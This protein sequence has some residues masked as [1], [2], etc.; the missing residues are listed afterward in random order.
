M[1]QIRGIS[2]SFGRTVALRD[3]SLE[4]AAGSSMALLGPNGAGKTT[5]AKIVLGLVM[6]DSGSA[7][8][9]SVPV[10]APSSRRGVRYLPENVVFHAWARPMQLFGQLERIR[11]S[12]TPL[13][14][15]E[16]ASQ[17]ACDHLL[18]RPMGKMSRGQR[19]RIAL[20][21]CTCGSP[22]ILILDEP[23]S[24]LDPEG[25]V[26][27]RKL[28]RSLSAQGAT[29]LLNSHLLGEVESVCRRAAFIREGSLV[30]EGDLEELSRT[31]GEVEVWSDTP[32]E[33]AD[34]LR[35]LGLEAQ[36]G[37]DSGTVLVRLG[38]HAEEVRDVA[39]AVLE[40]GI[41]FSGMRRRRESLED[42]FLRM[43]KGD[44]PVS[45]HA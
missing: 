28:I 38:P 39:A 7:S 16:R 42:I 33:M 31:R 9:G 2:K 26:H 17:L 41:G 12:S 25:R 8:I 27:L 34:A 29:L 6:A 30:G 44:G 10:T 3:V 23:S 18:D 15:R 24:G 22:G 37:P 21:L 1:I 36:V 4:V 20:A 43:M 19:Q 32:R 35:G 14:F 11:R 45:E 5:L 13:Q 40:S